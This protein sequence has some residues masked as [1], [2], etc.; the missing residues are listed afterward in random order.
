MKLLAALASPRWTVGVFVLLAAGALGVLEFELS[1]TLAMAPAFTLLTANLAASIATNAR[2]RRDLP[3]LVFHLALLMLI[4]LFSIGRLTYFEGTTT[5][6]DGTEFDNDLLSEERGAWHGD[7]LSTLRFRNEG[8]TEKFP[9]RGNLHA[10]YNRV[11]WWDDAGNSY[12]AEIGDDIPL[13]LDGY[14]IYTSWRRGFSPL[15]LWEP[16]AGEAEYGTVQ[17]Q[18]MASGGS[19][20]APASDWQL[21]GGPTIWVM[22]DLDNLPAPERGRR[23]ALGAESVRHH[24]IVRLDNE[25]REVLPGET[26]EVEGGR[27]TYAGLRSWMGYRIVYDPTID[28]LNATVIVAV[29]SLLWFYGRLLRRRAATEDAE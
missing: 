11:R 15:F 4:A 12:V 26:I 2:F 18:E 27:L 22:L 14:R 25:R 8:F 10:T 7:G 19:G 9:E 6:T 20:F 3:L 1:A 28:W 16:D 24:L 13:V 21:P 5:L 29:G 17:L 23:D